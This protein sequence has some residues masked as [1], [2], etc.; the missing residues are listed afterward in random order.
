[1]S[2]LLPAHPFTPSGNRMQLHA[3]SSLGDIDLCRKGLKMVS[4]ILDKILTPSLVRDRHYHS[5]QTQTR[6]PHTGA[7]DSDRATKIYSPE[8]SL[9][10]DDFS[11]GTDGPI[12]DPDRDFT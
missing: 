12:F 7:F 3:V 11:D 8:G 4:R 10:M 2:R 9:M 6:Q 5:R 1:M